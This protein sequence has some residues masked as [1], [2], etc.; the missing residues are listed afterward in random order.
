MFDTGV[1]LID[2]AAGIQYYNPTQICTQ[3]QEG[4]FIIPTME[5][6]VI[7]HVATDL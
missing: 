5:I 3:F 6:A 7:D 4:E 2:T 1:I